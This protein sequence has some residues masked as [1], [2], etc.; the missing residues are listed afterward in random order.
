MFFYIYLCQKLEN[1]YHD[2]F[3][4]LDSM[5]DKKKVLALYLLR[6][7]QRRRKWWV[8]PIFLDRKTVGAYY[9]LFPML[10]K[11]PAR[12]FN[13]FRMELQDFQKILSFIQPLIQKCSGREP[14]SPTE[15]LMITLRFLASGTDY[16]SLSFYFKLGVSTI[17][18]I[19]SETCKA[20]YSEMKS[21]YIKFPRTTG[22][23]LDIAQGYN[24]R[25]QLP[26]CIGNRVNLIHR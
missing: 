16:H 17:S 20:I 12:F 6:K 1:E 18:S 4:F 7:R 14:I 8:H 23:W 26:N 2:L 21:D 9:I 22:Q 5:V 13:Y 15:R 10:L 3:I 11:Y 25:W 24:D 19:V